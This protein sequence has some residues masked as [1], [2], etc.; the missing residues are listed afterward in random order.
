MNHFGTKYYSDSPGIDGHDYEYYCAEL[1]R[2]KGFSR[3]SVTRG[4]GD[5]GIDIIAYANKK[6]FG[7]QCKYYSKPVGNSAVQEACAGAMFYGCN[8]AAV[9]TNN[10]FTESAVKLAAATGVLL[11]GNSTITYP[12]H[13]VPL[14]FRILRIAGIL[15]LG[16]GVLGI[17]LCIEF[18]EG[19][20]NLDVFSLIYFIIMSISGTLSVLQAKVP[21][22]GRYSCALYGVL[23]ALIIPR[24]SE[25]M[26]AII[27]FAVMALF[28][29]LLSRVPK[30][31]PHEED[32]PEEPP[33][34][35]DVCVND[36]QPAEVPILPEDF[37]SG[38]WF[39]HTMPVEVASPPVTAPVTKDPLKDPAKAEKKERKYHREKRM[40]KKD[41]L[42]FAKTCNAQMEHDEEMERYNDMKK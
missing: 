18:S 15:T 30:E 42:V 29:L 5:Q 4:S 10:G 11:W 16:I 21:A 14:R 31:K 2:R 13:R 38:D 27:F 26:P 20:K 9:M 40:S 25:M 7:I 36:D 34:L 8:V 24:A 39:H 1:L 19:S 41:L 28:S 23:A 12:V 37:E 22:I 3:V 17:A 35:P 6:K 32:Q 33:V